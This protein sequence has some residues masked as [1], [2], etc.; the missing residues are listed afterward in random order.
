ANALPESLILDPRRTALVLIDL[1]QGIVSRPLAPYDAR[2]VV[3]N[4]RRL[5]ERCNE[6]AI[7]VVLVHVAFSESGADRLQQPVDS[8]TPVPPGGMSRDWAEFTPE[9]ARLRADVTITKRQWGAFHGTELD[10]QLRRRGVT[11]IILG[12]I[13]T[14]FG[15]E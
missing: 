12:G 14:N 13:S 1:Q 9:I 3:D 2:Q 8:P 10:L 15:V 7:P 11:T 5:G 6:L 4:G